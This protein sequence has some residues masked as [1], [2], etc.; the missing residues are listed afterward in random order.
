MK[1]CHSDVYVLVSQPT[2]EIGDLAG[3]AAAPQL[4][5]LLASVPEER[6]FVAANVYEDAHVSQD[7]VLERVVEV[8]RKECDAEIEEVDAR[9][10]GMG[11][12]EDGPIKPKLLRVEF[13]GGE[14]EQNGTYPHRPTRA[15]FRCWMA[16]GWHFMTLTGG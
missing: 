2:L 10:G 11:V 16:L 6:R 4:K 12:V 1:Q 15:L 5:L 9:T 8:A 7:D 13:T 14:L 3:R